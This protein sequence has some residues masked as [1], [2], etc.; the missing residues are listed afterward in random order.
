[1]HRHNRLE[2]AI[3]RAFFERHVAAFW[4]NST[5]PVRFSARTTGWPGT[6]GSFGMLV[7]DFDCGPER[8]AFRCRTLGNAPGLQVELDG[9]AE[10]GTGALDIFALRSDIQFWAARDVPAVFLCN[11]RGESVS[12]TPML[13]DVDNASKAQ[14]S[15][16]LGSQ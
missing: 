13:A 8:F 11:Q 7:R 6:L 14:H 4:R 12:H 5:K 2:H 10:A 16:A 9:F 15:L 1:M 3:A